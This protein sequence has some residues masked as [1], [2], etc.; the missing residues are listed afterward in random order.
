MFLLSDKDQ[1]VLGVSSLSMLSVDA[2][3]ALNLIFFKINNKKNLRQ[4]VKDRGILSH[5]RWRYQ[6]HSDTSISKV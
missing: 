3:D 5:T 6:I 2:T 4:R 1:V